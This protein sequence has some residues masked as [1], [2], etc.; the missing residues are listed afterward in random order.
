MKRK[1]L[2]FSYE[3]QQVLT[4]NGLNEAL[5]KACLLLEEGKGIADLIGVIIGVI[6]HEIV[7]QIQKL[8]KIAALGN[9]RDNGAQHRFVFGQHRLCLCG[10]VQIIRLQL[11]DKAVGG[12]VCKF[13]VNVKKFGMRE[14]NF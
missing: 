7:V 12:A 14:A 11:G 5:C 6:L 2:W 13:L 3:E 1:Q 9:A 4:D 8:V 10:V